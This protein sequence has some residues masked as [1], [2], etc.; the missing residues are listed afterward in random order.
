[1]IAENIKE[2]LFYYPLAFE[3]N[4]TTEIQEL[5]EQVKKEIEYNWISLYA[6]DLITGSLQEI[7]MDKSGFNLIDNI[8]FDSGFGLAAWVAEQQRPILLSSVHRGQRFRSNPV[9]SFVCCP[10]VR[11][12]ITIGIL[13]LGHIRNNTYNPKVLKRILQILNPNEM[14]S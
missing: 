13:N 1:M 9:K 6:V 10:I 12:G 2:D 14:I 5:I 4:S 8:Q 7:A 3:D 11:D